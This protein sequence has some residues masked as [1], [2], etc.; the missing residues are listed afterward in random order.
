MHKYEPSAGVLD[1]TYQRLLKLRVEL[2]DQLRTAY[3]EQIGFGPVDDP[4][5]EAAEHRLKCAVLYDKLELVE[6]LLRP[7][8]AEER[9][10]REW[11]E[12]HRCAAM[13][14]L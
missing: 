4:E 11:W 6:T 5:K 1:E 13:M 14:R 8:W 12:E 2:K 7:F 10:W 9:Y 3:N